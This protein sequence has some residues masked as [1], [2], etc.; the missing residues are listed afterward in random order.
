MTTL[1]SRDLVDAFFLVRTQCYHRKRVRLQLRP[2]CIT[3]SVNQR[4]KRLQLRSRL[5]P[6]F[7]PRPQCSRTCPCRDTKEPPSC[8]HFASTC[9]TALQLNEPNH[10]RTLRMLPRTTHRSNGGMT[11]LSANLSLCHGKVLTHAKD[12]LHAVVYSLRRPLDN[13]PGFSSSSS[14]SLLSESESSSS[15]S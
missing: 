1:S 13:V 4:S 2:A 15:S 9:Y 10:N 5:V 14:L 8:S 11:A 3:L 6:P 7:P 12:H